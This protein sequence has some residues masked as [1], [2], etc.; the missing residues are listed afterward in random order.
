MYQALIPSLFNDQELDLHYYVHPAILNRARDF[1][2]PQ[3]Y[4][5]TPPSLRYAMPTKRIRALYYR[6]RIQQL[7]ER[8]KPVLLIFNTIEPLAYFNTFKA[9]R[10]PLKIGIVH[11]PRGQETRCR[12]RSE[13]ELYLC[14][15]EFNYQRLKTDGLVDGYLSPFFRCLDIP[16]TP[17]P[18][19]VVEIAVP[20]IVNFDRRHYPALLDLCEHL[21]RQNVE[22]EVV[23]NI[24][25]NIT[26]K[27]GPKF[28]RMIRARG[29]D[30]HFKVHS[31]LPDSIFFR[32]LQRAN[33]VMPLVVSNRES[34][35]INGGKVTLTFGHAG[36]YKKPMI[37]E[38]DIAS[39][40]AIPNEAC[41]SYT[42]LEGLAK[43]LPH[44]DQDDLRTE[45]HE[46]C[47]AEMVEQNKFFLRKLSR[48]HDAFGER[49][50]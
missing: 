45:R 30:R 3:V 11:N 13:G 14:L 16:R 28:R 32:Q 15:H 37:L 1:V 31:F 46:R 23:F 4:S 35:Y 17:S 48:N 36:A 34:L 44:L 38:R 29:F 39:A 49:K 26:T 12:I 18:Q 19:H 7:L 43:K 5:L 21:S 10:H 50:S 2:G 33:Y 25:G 40:W 22:T 42:S 47:I 27:D 6:W 41:V 24:L 8:L 20:G 9:I